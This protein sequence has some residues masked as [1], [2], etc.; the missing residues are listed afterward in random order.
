M[1]S[2]PRFLSLSEVLTIL[3]DQ[4]TRYGGEFGVRDLGLLS[5]AI[6]VPQAAFGGETLH[7][8]LYEMAAAYA[9]HIC[10]N[11]PFIDGNKR[12]ALAS[13]LIFLDLN[14]IT[15][16]DPEGTLYETMMAVAQSNLNKPDIATA[17]R[18]LAE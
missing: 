15:I 9:F 18:K 7:S 6:A 16:S 10:Q 3:R 12:V 2:N 17:F 14:G 5:S 1:N 11:H 13:A 8:D 4:I